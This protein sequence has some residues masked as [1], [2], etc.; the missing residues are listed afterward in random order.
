MELG[1]KAQS[2]DPCSALDTVGDMAVGLSGDP[3]LLL[4]VP[5]Q[6]KSHDQEYKLHCTRLPTDDK[7]GVTIGIRRKSDINQE[8][9]KVYSD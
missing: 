1:T 6:A 7:V 3:L 2:I 9:S 5:S 4:L 8:T